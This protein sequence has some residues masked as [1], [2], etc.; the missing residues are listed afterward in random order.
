MMI[1]KLGSMGRF[2]E[3]NSLAGITSLFKDKDKKGSANG[4][5]P[6]AELAR[7]HTLKSNAEAA[8]QAKGQQEA[9]ASAEK[10]ND[11]MYYSAMGRTNFQTYTTHP[12]PFTQPGEDF[13]TPDAPEGAM[14]VVDTSENS[15]GPGM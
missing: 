8:A 12:A 9:V 10:A 5:S 4:L 14:T 15:P 7:Q 11:A 2:S 1:R 6:A 13:E 3:R